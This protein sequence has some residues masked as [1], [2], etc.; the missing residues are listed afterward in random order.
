MQTRLKLTYAARKHGH[1]ETAENHAAGTSDYLGASNSSLQ[2]CL[3]ES[4]D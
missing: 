2:F 3:K 4:K 1:A